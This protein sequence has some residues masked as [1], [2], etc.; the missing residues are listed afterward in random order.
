M[1]IVLVTASFG[2]VGALI[3]AILAIVSIGRSELR[4][5]S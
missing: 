1:F 3:G 5:S 4:V 2:I